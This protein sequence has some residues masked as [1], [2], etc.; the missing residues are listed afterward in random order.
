[1]Q[2]DLAQRIDEYNSSAT[3]YFD[4]KLLAASFRNEAGE[5]VAGITGH[6]WGGC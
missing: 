5:V 6:T 2:A 4:G 1:M 3:G